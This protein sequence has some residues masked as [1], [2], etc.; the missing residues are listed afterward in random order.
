MPQLLV[1]SG[2][3]HPES[4]GPAT[5]L[6]KLLPALQER[7]WQIQVITYGAP[8]E[9]A[10]PYP[11]T[12]IARQRLPIRLIHYARAAYQP[13]RSAD[14]VYVHGIDLPLIGGDAPRVIKIVGDPAWERAIRKGWIAPDEDIDRFQTR[15]YGPIVT[16]QKR[17]R[18]QRVRAMDGVIVP[19]QYLKRLV[20]GWGVDPDKIRVIYNAVNMPPLTLSRDEA[21]RQLGLSPG[22]P[23]LFT[24]ARLVWWKGI[25]HLI[26]AL[27]QMPE[28]QL[29]IAGDGPMQ[30]A[31]TAQAAPLGDRVRF[32][33][34]VTREQMPLYYRAADFFALYSGYEGLS[35][36]LL[37]SLMMG[38]PVIASD[39]GGNPEVVREGHNG[40]LVPYGDRAAL[41]ESIRH[42]FKRIG[43]FDTTADLSAFQF[44]TM[45]T[46]TEHTFQSW[47]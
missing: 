17:I 37:E 39:K 29:I 1:A 20:S 41:I 12:R 9:T 10:Y 30:A 15:H 5:Y 18:D 38:T 43:Q 6:A 36:V 34:N 35:H 45:V 7:A 11:I 13:L 3:F 2:I 25:D 24:A 32:V 22:A 4:G 47:L 16:L 14:L 31:L 28:V 26:A 27:T 40:L 33:G 8:S 44:E 23:I 21:R 42:A 19:S 46:Q